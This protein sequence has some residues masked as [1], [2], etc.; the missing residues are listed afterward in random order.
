[1]DGIIGDHFAA[2]RRIRPATQEFAVIAFPSIIVSLMQNQLQ[3]LV[4]GIA[5]GPSLVR[6]WTGPLRKQP[7]TILESDFDLIKQIAQSTTLRL[8]PS[9]TLEQATMRIKSLV[10]VVFAGRGVPNE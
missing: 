2:G 7:L 8:F 10:S 3:I 5:S 9:E 4:T 1:M 6:M